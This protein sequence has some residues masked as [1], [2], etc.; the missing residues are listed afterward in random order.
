MNYKELSEKLYS[1]LK[2]IELQ[3]SYIVDKEEIFIHRELHKSL[4]CTNC[5]LCQFRR[6]IRDYEKEVGIE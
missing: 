6:T 2:D 4:E 1:S 3:V 5:L